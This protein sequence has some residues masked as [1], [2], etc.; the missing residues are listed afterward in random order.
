MLSQTKAWSALMCLLAAH[1]SGCAAVER[2][3][4]LNMENEKKPALL[5]IKANEVASVLSFF[6]R[7]RGLPADS[8]AAEYALATQALAKQ[9]SDNNRLKL[10]L[11]LSLPNT[12][13]RDDG[14]A[15]ALAEETLANKAIDA[16]LKPLALYIAAVAGEQKRQEDRYQAM[17]QKLKEEERRAEARQQKL[18]ALKTIEKDLINREQTK[19]L[20][21]K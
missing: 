2:A 17:S 1:L 19:P 7:I 14:R 9:R 18:D 5:P 13:F 8:L 10:A 20:R 15:A 11:L 21:V 16:E 4:P 6:Q 3:P 12:A